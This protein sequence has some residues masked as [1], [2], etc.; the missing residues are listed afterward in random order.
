MKPN[1]SVSFHDNLR[2]FKQFQWDGKLVCLKKLPKLSV[3][4]EIRDFRF[5]KFRRKGKKM[6][7][8]KVSDTMSHCCRGENFN[9]KIGPEWSWRKKTG[10]HCLRKENQLLLEEEKTFFAEFCFLE[11]FSFL[12]RLH[13][14]SP[15]F[16]F[17][18]KI[19]HEKVFAGRKKNVRWSDFMQWVE[20]VVWWLAELARD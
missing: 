1:H 7:I 14:E 11:F 8:K 6:S 19:I 5:E 12:E 3:R 10:C 4:S 18:S 9:F 2:H 15:L 20:M 16:N 13:N 17:A